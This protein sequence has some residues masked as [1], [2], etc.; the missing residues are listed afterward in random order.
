[1]A[2][3]MYL[4]TCSADGFVEDAGG[5][6]DWTD[7][8]E[9]VHA[10]I[11]ELVRPVGTYLHGRRMHETMTYWDTVPMGE[12]MAPVEREFA[13]IW[14]ATDTVVYSRT[15]SEVTTPR[16]SLEREFDP[17]AVR[18]MKEREGRDLGI[19]GAELAA[20][21]LAAGLIDELYLFVAPVLL[22]AGK[23]ALPADARHDLELLDQR[24]FANGTVFLHYGVSS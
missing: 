19:G 9:E 16:A 6:F 5:N 23:P 10:F 2:K 17:A 24:G 15:L 13:E 11:N 22:G 4:A 7:P 12:D 20:Q 3:L 21:A 8:S 14:H 1:M 18:Q